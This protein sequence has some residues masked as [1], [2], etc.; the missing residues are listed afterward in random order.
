MFIRI[1]FATPDAV[2]KTPGAVTNKRAV[3]LVLAAG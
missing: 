2:R 3:M 1:D